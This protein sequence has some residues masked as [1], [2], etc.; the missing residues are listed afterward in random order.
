MPTISQ[1]PGTVQAVSGADLLVLAQTETGGSTPGTVAVVQAP[2]SA[3]L[4]LVPNQGAAVTVPLLPTGHSPTV[5]DS[6]VMVQGGTADLVPYSQL[7]NGETASSLNTASGASDGDLVIVSQDGTN[8]VTQPMSAVSSYIKG[9]MPS[10]GFTPLE[11]STAQAVTLDVTYNGKLIIVSAPNV[12]LNQTGL[13]GGTFRADVVTVGTGT[14]TFGAGWIT[15][16]GASTMPVN[17]HATLFS[18]AYTGG[19]GGTAAFVDLAAASGGS[20]SA[21]GAPTVTAAGTV[22]SSSVV[23]NWTAPTTGGTPAQY[24]VNWRT[25]SGPGAWQSAPMSVTAPAGTTT[26]SGLSASTQY[27]VEVSAQNTGGQS[28]YTVATAYA[29]TSAASSSAPGLPTALASGSVTSSSIT[30]TWTAPTGTPSAASYVVETSTDNATWSAPIAVSSGTSYT[31]SGLTAA[32]SYYL[33]AASVA[34]GGAVSSYTTGVSGT[35]SATSYAYSLVFGVLDAG[36]LAPTS[37]VSHTGSWPGGGLN[38]HVTTTP[39]AGAI[40]YI[41]YSTQNTTPPSTAG[42]ITASLFN[43]ADYGTYTTPPSTAGTW[44]VWAILTNS[45]GTIIGATVSSA[46]TVT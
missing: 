16:S 29:T 31:A 46:I 39:P 28:A 15:S 1:L 44:Y 41:V 30:W 22:T 20:I 26:I 38:F 2:V 12:T 45:S 42:G 23:V 13:M 6:A 27:D 37:P 21:P 34:S 40:G 43:A 18:I 14:V 35:T 3:L 10:Y 32:T 36:S 8:L 4:A 11:I 25:T 19:G 9:K 24:N 5:A 17:S 7:V 33:R